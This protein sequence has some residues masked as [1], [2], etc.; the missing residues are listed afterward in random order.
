M[1]EDLLRANYKYLIASLLHDIIFSPQVGAPFRIDP[2]CLIFINVNIFPLLLIR[3]TYFRW[4]R[5]RITVFKWGH[6]NQATFSA[7]RR[8]TA[9]NRRNN[10][11]KYAFPTSALYCASVT[12]EPFCREMTP[13]IRSGENCLESIPCSF[14]ASLMR[15]LALF[16]STMVKCL[17]KPKTWACARRICTPREWN[18]P[19]KGRRRRN[20]DPR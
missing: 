20:E 16:L 7:R 4:S 3:S 15:E 9:P 1:F 18:V 2:S 19:T 12:S 13:A 6:Q 8:Y 14:T 17:F 5:K 11:R 10:H